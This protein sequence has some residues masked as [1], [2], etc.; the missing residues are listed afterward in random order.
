MFMHMLVPR[1][2]IS[3][4]TYG[5]IRIQTGSPYANSFL[6]FSRLHTGT[7]S[8]IRIQKMVITVC[9]Q[10]HF[11]SPYTKGDEKH[12]SPSTKHPRIQTDASVYKRGPRIQ[13][14]MCWAI[15]YYYDSD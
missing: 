4:F 9:K 13:M 6:R 7:F 5:R 1:Y 10:L 14:E 11:K 3:P 2:K 15:K 12:K 8:C